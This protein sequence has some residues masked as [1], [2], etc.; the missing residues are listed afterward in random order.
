MGHNDNVCTLT[1]FWI[2]IM[3][4]HVDF[5]MHFFYLISFKGFCAQSLVCKGGFLLEESHYIKSEAYF[6]LCKGSHVS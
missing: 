4:I 6:V 1:C 3:I 5:D 2:V